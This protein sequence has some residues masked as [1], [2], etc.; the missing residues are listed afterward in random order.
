MSKPRWT[1][2]AMGEVR[3]AVWFQ[4][5]AL[6]YRTVRGYWSGVN[7]DRPPHFDEL[8][9]AAMADP[10]TPSWPKKN[11]NRE[12]IVTFY[13]G[14]VE[15]LLGWIVDHESKLDELQKKLSR[16]QATSDTYDKFLQTEQELRHD[17]EEQLA[18][19]QWALQQA[20]KN[21]E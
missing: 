15:Y 12:D 4:R 1:D 18:T 7:G 10:R 8:R 11:P 6:R 5:L 14:L 2:T 9:N 21:R 20:Y 13:E 19:A 17:T 16:T 3:G